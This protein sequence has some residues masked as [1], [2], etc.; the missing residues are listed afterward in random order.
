[1]P[2]PIHVVTAVLD[3]PNGNA[4]RGE[5]AE[6]IIEACADST[7]VT[8][9]AGTITAIEANL[10]NYNGATP[11]TRP[12]L[13][14]ILHN[15][16]KSLMRLFQ[17]AADDDPENAIAIIESGAFRVKEVAIQQKHEFK[18]ENSAVSGSVN[19]SAEGGGPQ[20]CHDWKYSADGVLFVRMQPT[21]IA[22]THKDGL[23]VGQFAHFTHEIVTSEG[24]QGVSQVIK[25]MV[26]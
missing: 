23:P 5:R 7:Y 3:M 21:V 24:P 25:I 16:L 18:A 1:M 11:S 19:L 14:R 17:D 12:N 6:A 2:L 10:A 22:E 15:D 20:S 26:S 13:W 9:P 8:V 4:D